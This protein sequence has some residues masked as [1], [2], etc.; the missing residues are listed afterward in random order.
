MTITTVAPYF[1]GKGVIEFAEKTYREPGEGELL[2]RIGAN[3][4][5]GT[6]RKEYFGGVGIIPGHEAAGRVEQAGPGTTTAVGTR[7]AIYLM[8][9]CGGCRSCGVGATNQCQAKRQDVGQT[10]DGGFGPYALV[11]ETHFFPVPDDVSY[12][13]ATMLL[14]VMGTSTHALR[15]AELVRKDARSVYIAGAGPIGLGLLA[16]T[17]VWW[18]AD[19]EIHI[20]DVSPWRR[21]FAETFGAISHDPADEASIVAAQPD[22]AFDSS[23]KQSARELAIRALSQRGALICV[24]HGEGIALDVSRD[25]IAPERAVLGSEYFRFD[26]MPDNLAALRAHRDFLGRIVTHTYDVAQI[27]EAFDAF[28]AGETGKVVVTQDVP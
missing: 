3:A 15:R 17:R 28:L 4:I 6:D 16:M 27:R 18:G 11:H 7:G 9:Y 21:Q 20:S 19:I 25:L 13:A 26:E 8:D 24:G 12:V 23:G 2:V 5:C 1:R 10:S 14:D 22:L